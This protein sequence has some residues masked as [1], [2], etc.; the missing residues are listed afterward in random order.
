M[1]FDRSTEKEEN[2]WRGSGLSYCRRCNEQYNTW[3]KHTQMK[4]RV[5]NATIWLSY[6]YYGNR[7]SK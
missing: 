7:G 3:Y 4:P 1:N 2:L 6:W 5:R